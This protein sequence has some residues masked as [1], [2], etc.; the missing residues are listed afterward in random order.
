MQ[1]RLITIL[2]SLVVGLTACNRGQKPATPTREISAAEY[3]VLTAW[4]DAKLA[5]K[6]RVGKGTAKVVI[7]DTTKSGDDDLLGDENGR[8]IPWEKTRPSSA[9]AT[10]LCQMIRVLCILPPHCRF[11]QL[12]SWALPTRC[13]FIRGK[14]ITASH[15]QAFPVPHAFITPPNL[16]AVL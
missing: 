13:L 6:E 9:P 1:K 11:Q 5:G 8:P 16:C 3:E 14:L 4:I 15:A 7:F 2:L 12:H 10:R